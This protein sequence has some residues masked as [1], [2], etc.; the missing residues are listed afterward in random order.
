M[1]EH[2]THIRHILLHEFEFGHPAAEAHRNLSQ[3]FGPEASSERSVRACFQRFK[4]GNKKFED[5]PRSG[6]P[7]AISFDELQHPYEERQQWRRQ[8][9]NAE[10]RSAH[11]L[12]DAES[13]Q[14]RRQGENDEQRSARLLGKLDRLRRLREGEN[15]EQRSAKLLANKTLRKTPCEH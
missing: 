8:I 10:H 14:K 9:E 15:D 2:S 3:V 12:A 5:E 6:R 11:Q 13:Q 1:A 7:T 4:T